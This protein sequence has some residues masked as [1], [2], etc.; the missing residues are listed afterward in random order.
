[1]RRRWPATWRPLADIRAAMD[2][3][4]GLV[5]AKL[6]D[7]AAHTD[8]LLRHCDGGRSAPVPSISQYPTSTSCGGWLEDQKLVA[9]Q[10]MMDPQTSFESM[11]Q[12]SWTMD[13]YDQ[14]LK[15]LDD[16]I[17]TARRVERSGGL[18]PGRQGRCRRREVPVAE[19]A[20]KNSPPLGDDWVVVPPLDA[21]PRPARALPR[22]PQWLDGDALR[23]GVLPKRRGDGWRHLRGGRR[24]TRESGTRRARARLD[25]PACRPAAWTSPDV[26]PHMRA[27]DAPPPP[28]ARSWRSPIRTA[29]PGSTRRGAPAARSHR[30]RDR[31]VRLR[32][33]VRLARP[34]ERILP[35]GSSTSAATS[36]CARISRI[37]MRR[38]PRRVH[39]PRRLGR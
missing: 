39:P 28:P 27:E 18:H 14:M 4:E 34:A 19:H 10:A 17:N 35:E 21:R 13:Y 6:G 32:E 38:A 16:G 7:A 2:E 37:S 11:Q 23:S 31:R 30:A 15:S 22:A 25:A 36:S 3:L 20:E 24:R 33:S 12:L 9:Q 8:E 1:M 5:D 29:A 26:T